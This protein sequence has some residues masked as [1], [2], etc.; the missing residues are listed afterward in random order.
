M[1]K[2]E[3]ESEGIGVWKILNIMQLIIKLKQFG[4]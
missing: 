3:I 1:S 2:I 4:K